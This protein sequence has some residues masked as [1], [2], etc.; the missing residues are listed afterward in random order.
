MSVTRRTSKHVTAARS[1]SLG[2]SLHLY[3]NVPDSFL[4]EAL[5]LLPQGGQVLG[6][7]LP[8]DQLHHHVQPVAWIR[9][10]EDLGPSNGQQQKGGRAG[11]HIVTFQ[12]GLVVF[13]HVG[14]FQLQE[15]GEQRQQQREDVG[16]VLR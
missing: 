15:D 2:K 5:L 12:K 8:L 6:Q 9:R 13:D 16:A 3:E 1:S 4:G 11:D 10:A 14:V 7:R